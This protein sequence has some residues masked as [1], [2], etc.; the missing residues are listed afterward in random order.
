MQKINWNADGGSRMT[1]VGEAQ[2]VRN[3]H[4]SDHLKAL[5]D[6]IE[7]AAS[8]S[9]AAAFLKL[10]G[11]GKII[12]GL[13]TRLVAGAAVEMFIGRDFCL[14]EPLA[15]KELLTL[16]DQHNALVVFL[17]KANPRSTFHPKLYLGINSNEARVLIGSANLTGGALTTNEEM[18]LSWKLGLED[19]LLKQLQD[20][21]VEYRSKD[22]FEELDD[23]VLEQYRSQFKIAQDTKRR[24]EK[25]MASSDSAKANV[26][27][28]GIQPESQRTKGA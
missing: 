27:P 19:A 13:R 1:K 4:S 16:S 18:S 25:E 2:L 3:G 23:I 24:I 22:R 26:P 20:V 14:T 17:A 21:F 28:R 7:S 10:K 12:D 8:I 9:I 5:H 15:L 11:L 6:I